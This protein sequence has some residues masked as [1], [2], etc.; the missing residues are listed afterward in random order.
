[1][2]QLTLPTAPKVHTTIYGDLKGNPKKRT[3]WKAEFSELDFKEVYETEE[4][5][6]LK[7]LYSFEL[8]GKRHLVIFTN[9]AVF[10]KRDGALSLLTD[11]SDVVEEPYRGFFFQSANGDAGF[12]FFGS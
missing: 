12:Y 2:A 5:I 10:V 1:M 11:L 6:E 9:V 4:D 3:G 8:G 7:N